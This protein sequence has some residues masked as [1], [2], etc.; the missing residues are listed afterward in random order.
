MQID[1][2]SALAN[3]NP[4]A[5]I[6]AAVAANVAAANAYQAFVLS[7]INLGAIVISTIAMLIV[8]VKFH[9]LER[10]TNSIKDA[11]VDATRKLAIIEGRELRKAEEEEEDLA[12]KEKGE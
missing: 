5:M 6:N 12:A 4:E 3:S 1:P 7:I 9:E 2:I 11:L 10:N 8:A